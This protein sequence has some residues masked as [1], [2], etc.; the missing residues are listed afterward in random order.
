MQYQLAVISASIL[1]AG[2][3]TI[4]Q[5]KGIGRVGLKVACIMGTDFIFVS[6]LISV[7]SVL[8]LQVIIGATILGND[9][10]GV[11]VVEKIKEEVKDIS[12]DIDVIIGE[13]DYLYW[14]NQIEKDDTIVIIDSTYLDINPGYVSYF[15]L[16]DCNRFIKYFN[17]QHEPNLVKS[18]LI[19]N[20]NVKGYLIGIEIGKGDL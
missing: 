20:L 18:I 11:R 13:T 19:E 1:S 15:D 9:G 16:K 3:A 12:D 5:A 2:I 7:G 8:A 14:L 6:P 17:S 4:I 10:V